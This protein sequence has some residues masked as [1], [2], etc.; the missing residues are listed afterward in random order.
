MNDSQA[1]ATRFLTLHNVQTTDITLA[2]V[3]YDCDHAMSLTIATWQIDG[4]DDEL[5]ETCQLEAEAIAIFYITDLTDVQQFTFAGTDLSGWPVNDA[6]QQSATPL[7]DIAAD[8]AT[9]F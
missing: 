7:A 4:G 1:T 6:I 5:F 2:L 9:R 3:A 8:F